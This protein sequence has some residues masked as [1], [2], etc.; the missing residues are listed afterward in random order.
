MKNLLIGIFS[1]ITGLSSIIIYLG[2]IAIHLLTCIMAW[3]LS[4]FLAAFITFSLP[5]VSEIY[6]FFSIWNKSG[7][8]LNN[9]SI[10]LVIY[11][12]AL[13]I[14]F[15]GLYIVSLVEE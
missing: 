15:F 8:F 4:G 9:Y 11:I 12:V 10:F 1:I 3:Q 5:I 2:G 7:A 6:W 14:V 13:I